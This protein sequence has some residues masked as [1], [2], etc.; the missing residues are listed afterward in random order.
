[1]EKKRKEEKEKE[2]MLSEETRTVETRG[3]YQINEKISESAWKAKKLQGKYLRE[4]ER[5][6]D[7]TERAQREYEKQ[8]MGFF[9]V[10]LGFKGRLLLPAKLTVFLA[11]SSKYSENYYRE[12]IYTLIS[13][14]SSTISW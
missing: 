14:N 8:I 10:Y 6:R 11:N 9:S 13:H 7:E 5:E 4:R 3:Y 2:K 12:M 1:M